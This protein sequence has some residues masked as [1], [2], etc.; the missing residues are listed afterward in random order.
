M[1][2]MRN[3]VFK[4]FEDQFGKE[5][6]CSCGSSFEADWVE[7]VSQTESSALAKYS[8][9]ICGLEQM[10]AV[11]MGGE[12]E[13]SQTLA[14]QIPKGS[15]TSDDVLDVKHEIAKASLNQIKNLE[16]RK[17]KT[18]IPASRTSRR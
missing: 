2:N 15:L 14:I 13:F 3:D 8:C 1:V 4:Q 17:T 11:S 18:H 6:S 5:W 7:I 12:Q 9:Q 16:K 10:F